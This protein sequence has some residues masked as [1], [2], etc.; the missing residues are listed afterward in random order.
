MSPDSWALYHIT[1]SKL[2]SH[3]VIAQ[4]L[5]ANKASISN[6]SVHHLAA[7]LCRESFAL[8]MCCA[9][10]AWKIM[11]LKYSNVV[12]K[13]NWIQKLLPLFYY[14]WKIKFMLNLLEFFY[15]LICNF[16]FFT[17]GHRTHSYASLVITC[18]LA[19]YKSHAS[20]MAVERAQ[21]SYS[22]VHER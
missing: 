10:Y 16:Y 21:F 20:F 7:P 4:V 22:F 15:I 11:R 19:L 1:N 13:N 3:D 5:T 12:N 17:I 14:L 9:H 8:C 6:S 18:L 2:I